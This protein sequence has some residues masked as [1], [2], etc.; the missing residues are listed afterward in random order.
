M[1]QRKWPGD[2][3]AA[4]EFLMSQKDVDKAHVAASDADGGAAQSIKDIVEA[5][6]NP[7]STVNIYGGSEH[8]VPMF[9]KNPELEPIIVNWLKARLAVKGSTE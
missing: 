9:A 6:K 1:M 3:D 8:G 4:Y 7:H 5:S 2:I